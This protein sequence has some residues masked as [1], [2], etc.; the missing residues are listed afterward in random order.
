[1]LSSFIPMQYL[2]SNSSK[3]FKGFDQTAYVQAVSSNVFNGATTDAFD[4]LITPM[5]AL[6]PNAGTGILAAQIPNPFKGVNG[7][8]YIDSGADI[9][10][11]ADG[12]TDGQQVPVQP[13]LVKSRGVDVIIAIDSV[14]VFVSVSRIMMLNVIIGY[15]RRRWLSR[16]RQYDCEYTLLP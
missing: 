6:N 10:A 4:V 12:G 15:G 13:L 14:S 11:L 7:N 9:L 16:G 5:K 2:G 1:M 8:A 3:C